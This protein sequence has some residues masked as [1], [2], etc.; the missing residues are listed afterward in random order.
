MAMD[1]TITIQYSF[2]GNL[3]SYINVYADT[4]KYEESDFYNGVP[5]SGGVAYLNSGSSTLV[6][7]P[8]RL[9]SAQMAVQ[10]GSGTGYSQSQLHF[11]SGNNI[12]QL[13]SPYGGV[14]NP[15]TFPQPFIVPIEDGI[16]LSWS[17]GGP[18]QA[19]VITAYP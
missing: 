6:N 18:I 10:Q 9:I 15:L 1:S 12:M 13:N 8:C 11:I 4:L 14:G 17:A 19:Q 7:G 2:G 5:T 16:V 3:P